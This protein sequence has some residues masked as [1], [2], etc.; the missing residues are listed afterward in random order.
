M[1]VETSEYDDGMLIGSRFGFVSEL[2][3]GGTS[4]PLSP[5]SGC[6]TEQRGYKKVHWKERGF[7]TLV[8]SS[9]QPRPLL[10]SSR[11]SLLADQMRDV[12]RIGC[13]QT[14]ESRSRASRL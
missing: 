1:R 3:T 5:I 7:N 11:V 8:E 2:T 4:P 14:G 6:L 13:K 12:E 10:Q 9:R